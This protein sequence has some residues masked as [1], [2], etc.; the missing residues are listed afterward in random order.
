MTT[1]LPHEHEE[2]LTIEGQDYT[3]LFRRDAS[4]GYLVT[5]E[6]LPPMVAFGETL[7]EA[8]SNAVVE[9]VA[10]REACEARHDSFA[11]SWPR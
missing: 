10:C 2:L 3:C 9:I 4:G 8:R 5:C 6:E 11:T 7:E 1:K